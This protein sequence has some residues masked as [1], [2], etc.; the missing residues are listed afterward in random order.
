MKK[1]LCLKDKEG[2]TLLTVQGGRVLVARFPEMDNDLKDAIWH[3]YREITGDN[4]K[5]IKD[6]LDYN[7]DENDFCS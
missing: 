1:K 2:R 5:R 7:S 4:D 3:F 6:F